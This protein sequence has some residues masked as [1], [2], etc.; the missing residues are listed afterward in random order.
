[1]TQAKPRFRSIE[2]Y[3]NYDNGTDRRYELVNGEL[4]ELPTESTINT[5]IAIFLIAAFLQAG[6]PYFRLGIKQQIAV[7][8]REVTVREPDLIVH[9]EA[10]AAAI[11]GQKQALLTVDMPAP[12]IAIEVVSPGEPGTENYN[13]DYIDKRRE[14]GLRGIPEYWIIDPSRGMITVLTWRETE[15]RE[16][17]QFRGS[18]SVISLAFPVDLKAEQILSAG[19]SSSDL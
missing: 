9:S 11:A 13:R 3:L 19:Q 15:Y 10:S 17:G 16:I 18:Q 5:Q 6:L 4:V 14:Y 2:D 12:L 7:S 8:S 1:M